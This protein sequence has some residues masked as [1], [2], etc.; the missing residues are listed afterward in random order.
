MNHPIRAA[1]AATV[2]LVTT[3]LARCGPAFADDIVVSPSSS[4]M[5]GGQLFTRLLGWLAQAA[6]YGSV[7]SILVGGGIWGLSKLTGNYEGGA[8]GLKLTL[9]GVVGALMV[10]V[11]PQL[12]NMAF[13]AA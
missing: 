8:K 5:P 3:A 7:A 13:R 2:A 9:G 1:G 6:L 4:G 10:G 12:V 11:A